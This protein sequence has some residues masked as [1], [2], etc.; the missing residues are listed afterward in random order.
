MS[1]AFSLQL[2]SLRD[3]AKADLMDTLARVADMGYAAVEFAGLHGHDPEAVRQRMDEV[4]LTCSG[5]HTMMDAFAEENLAATV[6][7]H[8]TLGTDL[9]LIPWVPED[10]RNS[11][12]AA[13]ATAAEFTRIQSA[14]HAHGLRTGFHVHD[15]DVKPLAGGQS[16]WDIFT[17]NTPEAFVMQWDTANACHA[18]ADP[19]EG[20]RKLGARCRALHLK[21]YPFDGRVIGEGQVP[22]MEV[23]EA[24]TAAGVETYVVEQ[25]QYGDRTPLECC[26]L[27]LV[28]LREWGW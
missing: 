2:Y 10:A 23:R 22:W 12:E 27:C 15:A 24:A 18:G 7:L 16:A 20:I 8:R 14:L 13:L 9:A 1:T 19:V 4:G 6:D 26:R 28:Q 21:E 25:E 3:D 11:A 17:A 5:T